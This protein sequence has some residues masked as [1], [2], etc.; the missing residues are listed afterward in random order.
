MR[1][2]FKLSSLNL[3]LDELVPGDGQKDADGLERRYVAGN[4]WPNAGESFHSLV[5]AKQ[6]FILEC[7]VGKGLNRLIWS[8]MG[9]ADVF[10]LADELHDAASELGSGLRVEVIRA[11]IFSALSTAGQ[12]RVGVA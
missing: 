8:D 9:P 6:S 7:V 1:R 5:E 10:A 11:A 12:G 4:G 2:E 3:F